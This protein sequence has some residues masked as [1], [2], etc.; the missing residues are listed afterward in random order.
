MSIYRLT[1]PLPDG[2]Q[3]FYD[4]TPIYECPNKDGSLVRDALMTAQIQHGMKLR[5]S[6][7]KVAQAHLSQRHERAREGGTAG[8]LTTKCR[9][10]GCN[11]RLK[12]CRVW[13]ER[14]V[15]D[16]DAVG[17][18][19]QG[20]SERDGQMVRIIEEHARYGRSRTQAQKLASELHRELQGA[21][22]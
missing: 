18:G 9:A 2:W 8:R 13:A 19:R 10:C 5:F 3:V 7:Q 1:E 22:V 17:A 6:I 11:M 21:H 15:T 16:S 12:G 14:P 20:Y 4:T